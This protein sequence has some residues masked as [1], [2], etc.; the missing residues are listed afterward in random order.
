MAL[1]LGSPPPDVIRRRFSVEPGLSSAPK[2]GG[3]PAD[4]PPPHNSGKTRV[5]RFSTGRGPPRSEGF[6][7][8]GRVGLQSAQLPLCLQHNLTGTCRFI[9]IPRK[10]EHRLADDLAVSWPLPAMRRRSPRR[11]HGDAL[12]DRAR[13]V[14]DIANPPPGRGGEN[15]A[16]DR[17]GL[18]AARIIVGNDHDIGERAAISPMIGRL[19]AS[20]SPPQPKT[21]TSRPPAKGR[22]AREHIFQRIG[23]MRVIDKDRR[24]VAR[25]DQL[26]PAG[27]ARERFQRLEDARAVG[28]RH[29]AEPG[30][31]EGVCGLE[32]A[33]ERQAT[34]KS[35]P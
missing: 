31:D 34:L 32:S 35:R 19:P 10:A 27:R 15:G 13:P 33:G 11:R 16:A 3:H 25:A 30:G 14:A 6:A 5:K 9:V 24:A 23:L 18:L 26:E 7:K 8:I 28:A 2:D 17:G 22:S 21:T 1:S 4:W 20:R 12:E 29:D